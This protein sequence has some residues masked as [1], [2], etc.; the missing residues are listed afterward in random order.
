MHTLFSLF[1]ALSGCL[2]L[3]AAVPTSSNNV[4]NQTTCNGNQ[5]T[6]QQLAGYGFVPA[7]A[8]DSYGDTLGGWGSAI[9]IDQKTWRKLKNGTYTGTLYALPDRGWNTQGTVNYQNRIHTFSIS[10]TPNTSATASSPSPPNLSLLYKSTLL[11]TDPTGNPTTG[12]EA[13]P[14]GGLSFPNF[15]LLPASTFTGN[16]FGQPGPGGKRL[17]IDAEGLVLAGNDGSYWLSDEY[18]PYIYHFSRSGELLTAIQPPRAFLPTRNNSISF[19]ADS[20]PIYDP[21]RTLIPADPQSG[22]SNNQGL[23]GLT[24]SPDGKTLYALL[25][26][27]LIQDGGPN[28]PFRRQARFLQYSISPSNA[29]NNK[30]K[31]QL[32]KEFVVS[33]PFYTDPTS[34][35]TPQKVAGQSE[36]HYL[37]PTQF[38]ILSRDSGSGRGQ[39]STTSQYRHLDI[40]D[41]S[42]ATDISSP[43]YNSLANS[44][45]AS[46]KGELAPGITAAEYCP[47]L[48]FNVNSQLARFGVHNGGVQD[49][50]LLNEKWESIAVVPV[51]GKKGDDGEFF[52]FSV[53]DND[54][55]TQ[56][57][58][59]NGGKFQYK[60][61][62]GFDLDNQALVFQVKVPKGVTPS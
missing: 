39:S 12:L 62:S 20:P 4:V 8:R 18:G 26:S 21:D 47:F 14:S 57:G 11:L 9:A 51:D 48:D 38:L 49:K 7:N 31:V 59:L 23:E 24:A 40:F 61:A 2:S 6:Y 27:A 3:T 22:R 53:S 17:S 46:S 45:I 29:P 36:I 54:F 16:G 44:S 41:T 28:Q 55:V 35:K 42:S 30:E 15:P 60:D 37:T 5:Y 58:Y 43:A 1:L 19:S 13:D 10:F 50:G 32:E 33:L 56:D 25:Q 52:V 34:K